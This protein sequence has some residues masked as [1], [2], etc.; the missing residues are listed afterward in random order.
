MHGTRR[1][2]AEAI[3][4]AEIAI[5]NWLDTATEL[6][7]EIPLPKQDDYEIQTE[8]DRTRRRTSWLLNSSSCLLLQ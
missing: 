2:R 1:T 8:R 7:R 4:E 6:G 5:E 3:R